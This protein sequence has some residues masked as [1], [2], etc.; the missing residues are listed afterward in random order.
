MKKDD[1]RARLQA[2]MK[3]N[4]KNEEN[5]LNFDD[6]INSFQSNLEL[7]LNDLQSKNIMSNH[8]NKTLASAIQNVGLNSIDLINSLYGFK[9]GHSFETLNELY[10]NLIKH[11]AINH[12]KNQRYNEFGDNYF[13]AYSFERK[14]NETLLDNLKLCFIQQGF[15]E[16]DFV[17]PQNKVIISENQSPMFAFIIEESTYFI[18]QS[19]IH[20]MRLK[21]DYNDENKI[22]EFLN[23]LEDDKLYNNYDWFINR[24]ISKSF[25]LIASVNLKD[26]SCNNIQNVGELERCLFNIYQGLE[27]FSSNPEIIIC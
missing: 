5:E 26:F 2:N 19:K 12:L 18:E 25:G 17:P 7:S 13:S 3:A 23:L 14:I 27:S 4:I 22:E 11:G 16:N 10:E 6:D 9:I 8:L 20:I 24:D 21:R 1:F 15:D